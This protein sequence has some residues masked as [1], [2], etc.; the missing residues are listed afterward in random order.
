VKVSKSKPGTTHVLAD[1]RNCDWSNDNYQTA[2]QAARRH[3]AS[4]GHTVAVER[5]QSW[6]YQGE[7]ANG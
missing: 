7:R 1:C 3:A 4:T 5:A 2:E 6:V